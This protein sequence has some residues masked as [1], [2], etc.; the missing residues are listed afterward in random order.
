MK[1]THPVGRQG[2]MPGSEGNALPIRLRPHVGPLL[3]GVVVVVTGASVMSAE[4]PDLPDPIGRAGLMAAVIELADG[5]LAIL[6]AGGANFPDGPP[7]DGGSKTF[8]REI[9]LLSREVAIDRW[10][11]RVIG[12][13]PNPTAYAA[14]CPS[15]DRRGMVVAGGCSADGHHQAVLLVRADGHV[16]PYAD[17]MPIPLAYSGFC[18]H[19]GRLV[20]IGGTASPSAETAHAGMISLRLAAPGEGWRRIDE[21]PR[22][23][24]ILFFCGSF[25]HELVWGGGCG[26]SAGPNGVER[27][28]RDR[29]YREVPAMSEG[30][31]D[32]STGSSSN[33]SLEEA[34]DPGVD[35]RLD[36]PLAATAGPAI[37]LAD[38]LVFVGGDDGR[39]AGPP[40]DHPGQSRTVWFLNPQDGRC[41]PIG[42]WPTP[43]V[44]AP[45]VRL[46]DDLVTISGETRPGMRTPAVSRMPIPAELLGR[47]AS[48]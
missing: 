6:A 29:V 31:A 43:I 26:I 2:S 23:A 7:W 37:P 42:I 46:D 12:Q 33:A 8:H 21:D 48:R 38:G 15:P 11:W 35:I 40:Q 14:F 13:L 22:K 9:L 5:R 32:R 20:I 28:Y 45:L 10:G 47:G 44:T 34:R 16:E 39:Y 41:R 3:V 24:G 4:L 19:D 17:P 30:L 18:V 36:A 27:R 25:G 1:T